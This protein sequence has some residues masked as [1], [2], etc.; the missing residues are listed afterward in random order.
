MNN[1]DYDLYISCAEQFANMESP[2]NDDNYY[3]SEFE[4]ENNISIYEII[5]QKDYSDLL[6]K[7]RKTVFLTTYQDSSNVDFSDTS[8]G[9]NLKDDILDKKQKY[10]YDLYANKLNESI[11]KESEYLIHEKI[12][13]PNTEVKDF[14]L[15]VIYF[16]TYHAIYPDKLTTTV[17]GGICLIFNNNSER[18]YLELYN[19]GGIGYI[20]ENITSKIL[21]ENEDL[22]SLDEIINRLKR[23]YF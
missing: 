2:F 6:N 9:D 13:I 18:L 19:D 4:S 23:F 14:A 16:L 7:I 8:E 20:I 3:L 15:N 22:H 10:L 17:E 5:N 21:I 1:K 11:S 12:E